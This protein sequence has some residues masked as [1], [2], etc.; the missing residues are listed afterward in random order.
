MPLDSGHLL[1][2]NYRNRVGLLAGRAT[3][4][5]DPQATA[6]AATRVRIRYDDGGTEMVK[7]VRLAEELRQIG[8]DRVD[9]VLHLARATSAAKISAI[10]AERRQSEG[11]QA[12]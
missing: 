8:R 10:V 1:L 4:R 12:A 2:Q 6:A 11:T 5:P 9:E 7:V 3:G